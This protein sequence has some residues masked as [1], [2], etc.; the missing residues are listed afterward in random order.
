MTHDKFPS[1]I[2]GVHWRDKSPA[3]DAALKAKM[4]RFAGGKCDKRGHLENPLGVCAAQVG[5]E[6]IPLCPKRLLEGKIAFGAV[7][8][9][10]F[11]TRNDIIV[12]REVKARG[13]GNF[14]FVMVRHKPMSDEILDFAVIEIQGGQTSSTGKLTEAYRDFLRDRKFRAAPYGFS[15]NYYDLWKRGLIQ[16]MT[17]GA[18][19][20]K[21]GKKIYW[22]FPKQVFA[23]F[24]EKYRLGDLQYDEGHKT[25]FAL[26]DL[27]ETESGLVLTEPEWRSTTMDHLFRSFRRNL[28]IPSMQE[29][30][31]LLQKRIRANA[32][33]RIHLA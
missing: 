32:P 19:M 25:V 24:Q 20:E 23:Y 12:F 5:G 1:E 30:L 16:V 18:V 15:L 6:N 17:K 33:T 13:I 3:A 31:K 14:D 7:A 21:W 8:D 26:C 22:V 2:F 29:F 9:L 10:H 4:C 28:P 11:G 27:R